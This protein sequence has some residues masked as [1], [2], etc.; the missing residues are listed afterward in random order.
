[1]PTDLKAQYIQAMREFKWDPD[2]ALLNEPAQNVEVEAVDAN[3]DEEEPE[4]N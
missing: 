4:E 3:D 2:V 1:L